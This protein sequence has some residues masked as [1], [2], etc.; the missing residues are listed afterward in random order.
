MT[1]CLLWCFA[2]VVAYECKPSHVFNTLKAYYVRD[3]AGLYNNN[4]LANNKI[5]VINARPNLWIAFTLFFM[6]HDEILWKNSLTMLLCLSSA[7]FLLDFNEKPLHSIQ[8]RSLNMTNKSTQGL[9]IFLFSKIKAK[10]NKM[11]TPNISYYSIYL[12]RKTIGTFETDFF[13][14][15]YVRLVCHNYFS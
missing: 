14:S 11:M 1:H 6:H 7:Y 9:R 3:G 15:S 5:C 10:K 12:E 8:F 13:S 2:I 4:K